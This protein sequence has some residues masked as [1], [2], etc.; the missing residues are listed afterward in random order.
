MVI[1]RYQG[2]QGILPIH[3]QIHYSSHTIAKRYTYTIGISSLFWERTRAQRS[4]SKFELAENYVKKS[5]L[6]LKIWII[7]PRNYTFR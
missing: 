5:I 3:H 1:Y 4:Y 6:D 7:I 2:N